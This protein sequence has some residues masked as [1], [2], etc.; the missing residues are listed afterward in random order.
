[1]QAPNAPNVGLEA[2]AAVST[3]QCRAQSDRLRIQLTSDPQGIAVQLTGELDMATAPE[4]DRRLNEIDATKLRRLLI[5]LSA[6]EFMD[7]AGLAAIIRAQQYANSNGH[8]LALRPGPRQVQR[9]F[10]LTGLR[11][12]VTFED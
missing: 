1:M 5:D 8:R 10:E 2:R 4:L 9:L 3:L 11:D 7:S 12:R 6:V